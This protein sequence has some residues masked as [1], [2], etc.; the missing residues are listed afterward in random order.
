[1]RS[2]MQILVSKDKSPTAEF[3]ARIVTGGGSLG[4]QEQT[5]DDKSALKDKALSFDLTV[6]ENGKKV[7]ERD[8]CGAAKL[9]GTDLSFLTRRKSLKEQVEMK[10][11]KNRELVMWVEMTACK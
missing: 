7:L 8:D 4:L 11:D 10:L 3:N 6:D 5:F 9:I 2:Q 1:M